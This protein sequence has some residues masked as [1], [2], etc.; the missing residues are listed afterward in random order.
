[1]RWIA[2][3][4]T[5]ALRQSG[6]TAAADAGTPIQPAKARRKPAASMI[7]C[8]TSHAPN[9]STFWDVRAVPRYAAWRLAL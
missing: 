6:R 8:S 9:Q 5:P 2:L 7:V 4:D 1:V 3:R